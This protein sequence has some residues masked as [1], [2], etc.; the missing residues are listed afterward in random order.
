MC[1]LYGFFWDDKKI[2]L[3]LEYATGGEVYQELL[4]SPEKRFNESKSADYIYQ[5][6]QALKYL[7][8]KNVIHRDIKPE[9]LLNC[10]GTIK[11]SDFGW[12]THNPTNDDNR[13]TFCGT[14][15]YL[16]PEM[17]GNK[18]YDRSVDIWSVGI[19]AYEFLTG[20]PPF[21]SDSREATF[22][23]IN[24]VIV[25]YPS[26]LSKEAVDFMRA[27]LKLESKDRPSFDQLLAHPW[28]A[29]RDLNV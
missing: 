18:N 2:Y 11:L 16:P 13:K 23:K 8:S 28:L 1:R 27:I 3:I 22:E 15:D 12:S 21:E 9:N 25:E 5:V 10:M 26:Y 29:R 4:K 24:N 14:L 7:H 19:L 17:V 6:I 20:C